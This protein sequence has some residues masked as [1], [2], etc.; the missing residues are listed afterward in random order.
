MSGFSYY[1]G[2]D[3]SG[4]KE[5]LSNLWTAI[6][7]EEEGR[8]EIVSL[9][10]HAFRADLCG[11]VAG[12][13]RSPLGVDE[14]ARILWGADFPFGL[15]GAVAR[16]LAGPSAGW[17]DLLG[18]IA[19]RPADEVRDGAPDAH[20]TPRVT[21]TGGAMAPLDTRIYKQT[22][23]GL[24]WLHDLRETASVSVHPHQPHEERPTAI[25]EVYPSGSVRDLG[26]PR[27]RAPARPGEMRAR[28]AALRPFL[29]FADPCY[30]ATAV[31]LEDAWDSVIACLTAYL[32]RDDLSQPFRASDEPRALLQ[33][34][35]WIYR[36]PAA[37]A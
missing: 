5:P 30:E 37:V 29:S 34:E 26:L 11:Y 32:A 27:R 10:P 7:R 1:G 17:D 31:S 21:D 9:R 23:E 22:V 16:E 13:W 33:L 8:L 3:F 20:R 14:E 24:R 19:D 18:W 2:I 12:A 35:G 6:G 28:V 15:P 25:L 4:A 36:A